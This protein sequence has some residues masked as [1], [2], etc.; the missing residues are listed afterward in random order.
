MTLQHQ[1]DRRRS[2]RLICHWQRYLAHLPQNKF[3]QAWRNRAWR[4]A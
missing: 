2:V 3:L 1:W 4:N